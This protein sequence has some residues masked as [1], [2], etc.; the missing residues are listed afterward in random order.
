MGVVVPRN[1]TPRYKG[2]VFVKGNVYTDERCAICGA[3]LIHDER[4][5]GCFCPDH[6][7]VR[8]SKRFR[9]KYG[10]DIMVRFNSYDK[11]IQFIAGLRFKD[12][13]GVLDPRDYRGD[14]PLGFANQAQA[15]LAT[16]KHVSRSHCGN[17]DRYMHQAIESWGQANVKTLGYA[18]IE[19]LLLGMDVSDKTRHDA[20][21]CFRQFFGWLKKREGIEPPDMPDIQFTLGWREI[22]DLETQTAIIDEIERIVPNRR[23]WIGIKWLATYISIRPHEMRALRE[24]DIDV[25]GFL[26][27]RPNTIKEKKPKLVPMLEEDIELY[28]S[29]PTAIDDSMFFFRREAGRGVHG[30]G[31]QIGQRSFYKWWK[32]ACDNLGIKGVDLYGGTRHSSNSALSKHFSLEQLRQHG[33][34]HGTN[35]AFERYARGEV[36]PSTDIYSKLRK[37]A[38]S[39]APKKS[40]EGPGEVI[41][42]R[43]NKDTE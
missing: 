39:K 31:E 15:W 24:R 2:E 43:Q 7:Q 35:K 1:P 5:A 18:E 4:R 29:M 40:A 32:R 25:N 34:M 6:P 28:R 13:E 41:P 42:L 36:Q 9:A 16:K 14:N 19:D 11:A 12:I 17:L 23:I 27:C 8:A 33:T 10:R 37:M 30:V 3:K 26:V 22:I 38:D 21:S 20:L